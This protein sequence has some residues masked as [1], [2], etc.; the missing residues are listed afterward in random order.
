MGTKVLPWQKNQPQFIQENYYDMSRGGYQ[1]NELVYAC[2]NEIAKAVPEAPLRVFNDEFHEIKDH[3]LRQLIKRPNPFITEFELWELTLIY[4]YIAGNAYWEKVRSRSGQVVELYPLRPDRIQIV[5]DDD[6][7]IKGYI[8]ELGGTKY[9]IAKEDIIHFKFPNPLDD[10][11]GQSPLRAALRQVSVDNEA[12]DFSKSILENSAIPGVVITTQSTLDDEVTERLKKKWLQKFGNKKRGEPAFLQEGMDIKTIGMT[13]TDLAFPDLRSISET[14]ICTVFQVPPILIGAKTGIE[15]STFANYEEARKSFWQETISPLLM[16]LSNVANVALLPEF[17]T[18]GNQAIFDTSEVTALQSIYNER[19]ERAD[20]AVKNGWITV[21]EARTEA[22]FPP[23]SSGDVFIRNANTMTVGEG[24]QPQQ[25][26]QAAEP[27][28]EPEG[29]KKK[30]IKQIDTTQIDRAFNRIGFAETFYDELHDIAQKEFRQQRQDFMRYFNSQTKILEPHTM[31]QIMNE[32]LVL[33]R[34]WAIRIQQVSAAVFQRL[35]EKAIEETKIDLGAGAIQVSVDAA[36]TFI[37][38]YSYLF[39]ERVSETS[40]KLIREKINEGQA[41]GLTVAEQRNLLLGMFAAWAITRADA[42]AKSETIRASNAGAKFAYQMGGIQQL[43]WT[44][45]R[46]AC[47][48]C[49]SLD[50][51]VVGITGNFLKNGETITLQTETGIR[52]FTNNY[53]NIGFPPLHPNCRCT[54]LPYSLTE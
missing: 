1:K 37:R 50:G 7:Y 10:F 22:G 19:W 49:A 46:D 54:I 44:A 43:V 9:P 42:I 28:P 38:E 52:N 39:A 34:N 14:R 30:S 51:T 8:Y 36:A 13:M 11:F 25:Q 31:V 29:V 20:K 2:I 4:M 21:N 3:P 15:R 18:S 5:P 33:A 47:P 27:E 24:Q 32:L 12:T 40:V 35:V 48:F 53:E 26:P 17:D 16:R 45:S 23:V 6:N 41:E